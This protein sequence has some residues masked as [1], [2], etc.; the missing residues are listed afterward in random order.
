M[1]T[2]FALLLLSV[3]THAGCIDNHKSPETVRSQQQKEVPQ[4][5]DTNLNPAQL[6]ILQGAKQNLRDASDYDLTM[7]YYILKYEN[8]IFKNKFVYPG[9][10]LDPSIGVCTDVIVRSLRNGGVM[11]LQR[12][13][14]EDVQ[15]N[16][17]DYPS[18]SGK[19]PDANI[20]H[21]RVVNLEI[22]FDKYWQR[23][24]ND[25]FL[26]GDIVVWDM[27]EDEI[28][29]HIGIVSDKMAYDRYF[30]IHSHPDPGYVAE[31]DK[32]FK[33]KIAGHYRVPDKN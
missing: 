24:T 28:S 7:G 29:D 18:M 23:I 33:W 26:P 13:I 5:T 25:E 6:K 14:H 12:E 1:K 10:D 19:K 11:D 20:D 32:L 31:E 4:T 17:S 27:N 16:K 3:Y 30:V 8:G 2:V 21:R 15:K 22:W 9:G